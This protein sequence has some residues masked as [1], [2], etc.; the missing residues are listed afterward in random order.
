MSIKV[1]WSYLSLNSTG[2]TCQ[3]NP[4]GVTC[5]LLGWPVCPCFSDNLSAGFELL[6]NIFT[7]VVPDITT[8]VETEQDY[9]VTRCSTTKVYVIKV[10]STFGCNSLC[11]IWTEFFD[12]AKKS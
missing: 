9:P 11:K 8:S 6:A 12:I 10:Q 2:V 4:T 5:Q 1:N 3:L 7:G